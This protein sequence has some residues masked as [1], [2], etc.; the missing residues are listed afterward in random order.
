MCTVRKA[1]LVVI[2]LV[3]I[4]MVLQREVSVGKKVQLKE[5][6]V[7]DELDTRRQ[8]AIQRPWLSAT[9]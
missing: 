9:G 6:D 2:M 5:D 7:E 3:D 8:S 4:S 1:I